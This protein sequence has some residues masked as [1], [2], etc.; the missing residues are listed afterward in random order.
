V[1]PS[2]IVNTEP[3]VAEA[4]LVQALDAARGALINVGVLQIVNMSV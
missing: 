1:L 3:R 2:L 4:V